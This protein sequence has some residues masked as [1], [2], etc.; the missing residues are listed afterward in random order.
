MDTLVV[1]EEKISLNAKDLNKA[2]KSSVDDI[3]L[4]KLRAKLEGKC[5]SSGWVIPNSLKLLSRSMCQHMSGQFTGDMI[6]WVQAEGAV[7]YP[8]DGDVVKGTVTKKNKMGLFVDYQNAMQIMVPRD[9]HIGNSAFDAVRIGDEIAVEIKKSKYQINDPFI[10]SVGMYKD[11]AP[12]AAEEPEA[13]AEAEESLEVAEEEEE[14]SL[15]VA[16]AEEEESLEVAEAEEEES[17][18]VAEEPEEEETLEPTEESDVI[19]VV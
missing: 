4:E 18:E 13:E 5:S 16:E 3:V 14:E 9:L 10:L 17:L 15:E 2:A 11:E 1:F 6:T 12:E 8:R 7:I 19:Q